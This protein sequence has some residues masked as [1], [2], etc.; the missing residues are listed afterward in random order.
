MVI[1]DGRLT[2]QEVLDASTE[3]L[4]QA[5]YQVLEGCIDEKTIWVDAVALDKKT[6]DILVL[7]QVRL[8]GRSC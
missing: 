2:A 8:T 3:I 7:L 6:G 5:G 4:V 1:P